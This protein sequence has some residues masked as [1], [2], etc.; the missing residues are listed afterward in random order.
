MMETRPNGDSIYDCGQKIIGWYLYE[1]K[2]QHTNFDSV[3]EKSPD[4]YIR[5]LHWKISLELKYKSCRNIS[6]CVS[7]F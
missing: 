3:I 7:Y 2:F 4:T 6:E 5:L 1:V